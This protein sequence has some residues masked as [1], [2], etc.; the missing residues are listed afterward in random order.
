MIAVKI[1]GA[2]QSH[3]HNFS[4]IHFAL[5]VVDKSNLI[6]KIGTQGINKNNFFKDDVPKMLETLTSR[7]TDNFHVIRLDPVKIYS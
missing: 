4:G 1:D 6:Q 3:G 2:D 5:F 7:I